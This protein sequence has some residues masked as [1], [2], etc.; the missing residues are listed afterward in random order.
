MTLDLL[1]GGMPRG[2]TTVAAKFMSLHPDMFC[3]AG[4]THLVPFMH[5][6][7]GHL[8][9]REDKIDLVTRFL[10]QQFM[11]AMVEMPRFS[12]SQGAH[13]GNLIFEE[14]NVADLVEAI[15]GH[16][17]NQLYGEDLYRASLVTL[18]ELLATSKAEQRIIL[19]EKTPNN[20]FAM[21]DY[22]WVKTAKNIV[23]MREPIGVLRSMRARVEGGDAYSGAF[24]GDLETNI[25]MYLEY[26]LAARQVLNATGES[27]LVR[28]EDIALAPAAVVQEMFS[29]FG[30]E[31]ED[32]VM[33][34]VEG[35]RDREIANRAPVNYKRLNIT[36]N[37]GEL[38]PVDIWKVFSLTRELREAFGYSDEAMREL[39]FELPSEWPDVEIPAKA[40]PLYGFHQTEGDDAPWMKR[41]G[42]L[43]VYLGKG[44]SHDITLEF[45]SE[46][47]NQIQGEVE[48]RASVNGIQ[49]EAL[50]V[51][52]GNQSTV[53]R[54]RIHADELVPMGNRGGY[55]II[56]LASPMAY[57]RIGHTADGVDAREMSFQLRNWKIDKALLD[58]GART[59]AVR[60]KMGLKIISI[61][62]PK[63]GGTS[64][65]ALWKQAFGEERVLMDYDDPPGNPSAT[66]LIDPVGWGESRPTTIPE[67]I[68]VVHGHFRP[69]KYD[70]VKDAF[71]M[72]ILRHPVDNLISIYCYWK[73]IP[74]QPNAVH[75][76]F[77][78]NN[79]DVLSL[80]RLPII[81]NLYSNTYFGG[82]DMGR[83]DFIGRHETRA[84]DLQRLAGMLGISIDTNLHLNATEPDGAN[85]E[86][87]TILADSRLMDQL[88]NVLTKDISFYE[89]HSN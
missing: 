56:D 22:A 40:L 4:E 70:L 77:L 31:V 83:L 29:L 66:F 53:V 32:R 1:I 82:W 23:V 51:L 87:E 68:Q 59:Q 36:A 50:T 88:R 64:T 76:Y 6:L 72:T 47:P 7:F 18:R 44:Q 10:H 30:L 48:L 41:R 35:N 63:A 43:V 42:G 12:V 5:S 80:A 67:P 26:A 3:Y 37:Y 33:Q 74:P 79:L 20:I 49:R 27:L 46:I 34:F 14:K 2:G 8:P 75:H 9:C 71:R 65:L 17:T 84:D 86:K 60:A 52:P 11:T 89:K 85:L 78:T 15:R 28:Y 81:Q 58:G 57:S 25:G 55:A 61:H 69:G 39:G 16:L 24:K 13:P 45:N 54:V 62:A 19:G 73:K 21:A 38:S